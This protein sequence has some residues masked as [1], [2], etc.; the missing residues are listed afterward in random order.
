MGNVSH[1][2]AKDGDQIFLKMTTAKIAVIIFHS[3]YK[4]KS[5]KSFRSCRYFVSSQ[6]KCRYFRYG[7]IY[8]KRYDVVLRTDGVVSSCCKLPIF[9]TI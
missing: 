1:V 4:I 9:S 8:C 7:I 3:I 5:N 2:G 6:K